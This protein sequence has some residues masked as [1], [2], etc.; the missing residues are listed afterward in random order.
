MLVLEF[1]TLFIIFCCTNTLVYLST[2]TFIVLDHPPSKINSKLIILQGDDSAS[3]IHFIANRRSRMG[4]TNSIHSSA[5]S[6]PRVN[7]VTNVLKR[8]F[9]RDDGRNYGGTSDGE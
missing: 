9:S 1:V 6:M 7:T 3:G 5:G 4:S 2:F 8:F